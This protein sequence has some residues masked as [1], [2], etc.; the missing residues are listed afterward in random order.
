MPHL[1]RLECNGGMIPHPVA[2]AT[3]QDQ[4]RLSMVQQ[5]VG[6][7]PA[8][9][10]LVNGQGDGG[11]LGRRAPSVHWQGERTSATPGQYRPPA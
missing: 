2:A 6:H 11:P 3:Q 1:A 4:V 10:A 5:K 7:A 9:T 8:I